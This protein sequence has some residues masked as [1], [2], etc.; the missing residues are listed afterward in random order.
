MADHRI[1]AIE[2]AMDVLD[3]LSREPGA[4]ISAMSELLAIPRSTVYRILNSLEAGGVVAKEGEG[5]HLGPKLVRWASAVTRG[6]DLVSLA[7]PHLEKLAGEQMA[8]VKLSV[9]EADKAL[10]VAVAES[11]RQY[12]ISTQ[13]GS[14]FPLHAGAASKVLLAYADEDMQRKILA[15]PMEAV[16]TSTVVDPAVVSTMLVEIRRDGYA[17]DHGEYVL[18]INAVAAPVFGPDGGCAGAMSVPYL[19]EGG[20]ARER[21]LREA[22]MAAANTLTRQIGGFRPQKV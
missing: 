22:V 9:L 16:T 2:R 12:S 18:G 4:T 1:P 3:I 8:A 5:Y 17:T 15:R 19:A 13:V 11:P 10:V 7:R 21:I 20:E 6:V 14:R